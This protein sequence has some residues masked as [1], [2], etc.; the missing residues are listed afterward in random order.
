VESSPREA[1]ACPDKAATA[2]TS[3][4]VSVFQFIHRFLFASWSPAGT[5]ATMARTS[6]CLAQSNK[7]ET[8]AKATKQQIN[9]IRRKPAPRVRRYEDKS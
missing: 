5:I 8:R 7:P 1:V 2:T 6:K 9:L 3:A 4:N